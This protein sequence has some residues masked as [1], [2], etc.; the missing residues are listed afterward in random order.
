MASK[1]INLKKENT[2]KGGTKAYKKVSKSHIKK[3]VRSISHAKK[4][5]TYVP[6]VKKGSVPKP[7]DKT[8][9]AEISAQNQVSLLKTLIENFKTDRISTLSAAL[10]YYALFSLAP[11]LTII[12]SIGSFVLS[13]RAAK[14]ELMTQLETSIGAPAAQAIEQM[15]AQSYNSSAPLLITIFS[16]VILLFGAL[17]IFRQI[18]DSFH[19]MWNITPSQ[20]KGGIGEFIKENFISFFVLLS[21]GILF[22]IFL[23]ANTILATLIQYTPQWVPFEP[24]LLHFAN[25]VIPFIFLTLLFALLY[26]LLIPKDVR[27]EKIWLGAGVASFLFN[28]GKIFLNFYLTHTATTSQ[29]GAAGSLIVILLWFY[30]SAHILFVGAEMIKILA[31]EEHHPSRKS[32]TKKHQ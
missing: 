27:W 14:G 32:A 5:D 17:G 8:L 10:S 23:L 7:Q 24:L 29:Y 3:H 19:A 13:E 2:I 31:G 21:V 28:I 22:I 25:F 12:V 30:Y 9:S 18:Q 16:S 15:L 11:L 20:E 6:H 1:N 4:N 26:K